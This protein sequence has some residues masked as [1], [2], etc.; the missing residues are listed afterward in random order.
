MIIEKMKSVLLSLVLLM[1]SVAMSFAQEI[2]GDGY[3]RVQNY[4]TLRYIY[5]IDDYSS[6]IDYMATSADMTAILLSDE[7][8]RQ[9]YDPACV[10]YIQSKGGNKYDFI[11]QGTKLSTI[12]GGYYLNLSYISSYEAYRCGFTASGMTVYLWD[13]YRAGTGDSQLTTATLKT[14]TMSYWQALSINSSDDSNYFGI[15]PDFEIDGKYYK[16]FYAAFP[17]KVKSSGM[18][19]YYVSEFLYNNTAVNVVEASEGTV[20]P[21]S[22]PVFIECSSSDFSNNRIDIVDETGS[23]LSS[24]NILSGYYFCNEKKEG[25]P[26]RNVVAYDANTMRVL[27]QM[28][29]GKLGYIKSS[30]LTYIPANSSYLTVPEGSPDE[31]PMGGAIDGIAKVTVDAPQS[32]SAVYTL[33]GVKVADNISSSSLPRGIYIVGGKKVVVK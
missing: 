32:S 2:T 1:S 24:N 13:S 25:N 4:N 11:A 7:E 30:T 5:L 17:F 6:G 12:S 19:V 18:K 28:S 29:N 15:K 9:F 3:Y 23:A 22:T 27:G 8:N 33:Q 26:H 21:A 16:S 31:M 20:I 14:T 10:I